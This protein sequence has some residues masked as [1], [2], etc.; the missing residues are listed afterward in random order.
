VGGFVRLS[1]GTQ[2]GHD[3]HKTCD[4]GRFYYARHVVFLLNARSPKIV[5]TRFSLPD[6]LGLVHVS[7]CL[8]ENG[9]LLKTP[10]GVEPAKNCFAGSRHAVWLQRQSVSSPGVE[11]SP[12][13]SQ[14][15][16]QIRHTPRTYLFQC[17]AEEL[18]LVLQFR[19]MPCS[20]GTPARRFA[21]PI[22]RPGLE[23]GPGPSEGP[24]Q[25][26][27]TIGIRIHKSRR[28]DSHQHQPVYKTR[29]FLS[30]A[31]SA[32]SQSTSFFQARRSGISTACS[33]KA[34]A[35]TLRSA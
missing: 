34:I 13:P 26:R 8:V 17:L 15:R 2:S 24:M 16:V 30:R 12:R 14:S 33:T 1:C 20:S 6:L 4:A 27:Y 21:S 22:S 7:G 35:L 11:P 25:I 23:P 5:A 3:Q 18:N 31:T 19:T 10:A 9:Q 28:L 32:I 29:A